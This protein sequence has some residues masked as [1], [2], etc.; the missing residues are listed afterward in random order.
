V[1]ELALLEFDRKTLEVLHEP[2]EEG[3]A[4]IGR[5]LRCNK[6]P[7]ESIL[8]AAMNPCPCGDRSVFRKFSSA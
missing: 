3:E 7:A 2:V 5:A 1:G 6:F 8:L 4:T